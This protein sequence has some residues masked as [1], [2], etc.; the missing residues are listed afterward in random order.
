[1]STLFYNN[2]QTI[3]QILSSLLIYIS[4]ILVSES[5][6]L[7][8]HIGVSSWKRKKTISCSQSSLIN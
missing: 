7:K 3:V 8:L 6:I 4:K 1:M 2:L 5:E